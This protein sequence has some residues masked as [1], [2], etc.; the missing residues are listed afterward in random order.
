MLKSLI[1]E[2]CK[3]TVLLDFSKILFPRYLGLS[4]F[5]MH[6]AIMPFEIE[7]CQIHWFFLKA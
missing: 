7:F 6:F 5:G 4:Y 2:N 3:G 1:F